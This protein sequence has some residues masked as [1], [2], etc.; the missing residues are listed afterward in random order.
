MRYGSE[1]K[2]HMKWVNLYGGPNGKKGI[3][4]E[5]MNSN[6]EDASEWKGRI[7]VAY[8]CQKIKIPVS[9][10]IDIPKDKF[11]KELEKAKKMKKFKVIVDVGSAIRLI[12]LE[13]YG[14]E[15]CIGKES[16]KAPDQIQ[17]NEGYCRWDARF[18][19]EFE[20][21]FCQMDEMADVFIYLLN[22]KQDRIC[23]Y[24]KNAKECLEPEA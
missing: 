16:F 24:R 4:F 14:L 6:P 17:V 2:T 10:I 3:V 21:S 7:L 1:E 8:Y 20:E 12:K 13:K 18:E 5:H 19:Y 9:K 22:E 11:E 15:I 23:Y